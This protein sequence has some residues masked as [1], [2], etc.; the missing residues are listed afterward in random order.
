MTSGTA[1]GGCVKSKTC[2]GPKSTGSS[3]VLNLEI[4]LLKSPLHAK[5]AALA[6][7]MAPGLSTMA[8]AFAAFAGGGRV[9]SRDL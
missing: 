1:Y 3:S 9:G 4:A 7:L 2:G 5:I 6:A 8:L